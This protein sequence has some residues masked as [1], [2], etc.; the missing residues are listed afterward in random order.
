MCLAS[1]KFWSGDAISGL[2]KFRETILAFIFQGDASFEASFNRS[3]SNNGLLF[4]F[5][6]LFNSNAVF[7]QFIKFMIAFE[8]DRFDFR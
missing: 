4:V 5:F 2:A 3:F 1:R 8:I 6:L 7:Y